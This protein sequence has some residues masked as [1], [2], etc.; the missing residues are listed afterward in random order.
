[1]KKNIPPYEMLL[2][3]VA[4]PGFGQL[5]NGKYL[6]AVVLVVLEV[7]INM[8]AKLN[9]AIVSSFQG[10]IEVAIAQV[11]YQWLMFYPCVYMFSIYDAYKDAGGGL[12]RHDTLPFVGCAFFGTVGITYSPM[13]RLFG[14]LLGPVW[15]P[16]LFA[17]VGLLAGAILRYA[18]MRRDLAD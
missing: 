10:E 6:K 12:G 2:W 11:N 18:L 4:L 3:C 5:L 9:S 15:C 7:L 13:F 17:A 8:G 16:M 1:M 14:T